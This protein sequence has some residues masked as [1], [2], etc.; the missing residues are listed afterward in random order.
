MSN[1]LYPYQPLPAL[2]PSDP[3]P[4]PIGSYH[5]ALKSGASQPGG[6]A[7]AINQPLPD[8]ANK[9]NIIRTVTILR[10]LIV[11]GRA[12]A[13]FQ[14]FD[15]PFGTLASSTL[16]VHARA[17]AILAEIMAVQ[18]R[19]RAEIIQ[20][21]I[22]TYQGR[23]RAVMQEPVSGGDLFAYWK[24][25]ANPWVDEVDGRN[26]V[27]EVGGSGN[28]PTI[29][30]NYSV[31]LSNTAKMQ[32]SANI[33][34]TRNSTSNYAWELELEVYFDNAEDGTTQL[35]F[36]E[37]EFYLETYFGEITFYPVIDG[38]YFTN[39]MLVAS[40]SSS[41]TWYTLKITYDSSTN[42]YETFVNGTSTNSVTKSAAGWYGT[43][44]FTVN[45]YNDNTFEVRMKNIKFSRS[46]PIPR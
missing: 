39:S 38:G 5:L 22:L 30:G 6:A 25:D 10:G 23:A 2:S 13:V 40:S 9:Q 26:L 19:A 29:S 1:D 27:K 16:T 46:N 24:M 4:E 31:F 34:W 12:S 15:A 36:I 41:D 14:A 17:S 28:N 11:R 44:K 35:V 42:I 37:N 18:V 3:D 33:G 7:P 20:P 8:E 32:T 43:S 21:P 45:N